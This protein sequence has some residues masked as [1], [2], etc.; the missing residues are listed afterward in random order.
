MA[1]LGPAI[2]LFVSLPRGKDMDVWHGAGHVEA[3]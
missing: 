1:G 2:R 3:I